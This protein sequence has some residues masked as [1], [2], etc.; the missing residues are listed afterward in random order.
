M[1]R[2]NC[3]LN[4]TEYIYYLKRNKKFEKDRKFCKHNLK[5]F[6]DVAR[7][8]QLINIEES[9]GFNKEIIYTTAILHDIGKSLQYETGTPHEIASWEISKE[10]LHNYR[11]NEEEI[12][13]IRQGILGHRDKK[14]E[15]FAQLMYRAD[16]LSRLCISCKSIDE[17]NWGDE[18]KNFKIYY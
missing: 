11:Y 7:I 16:K 4:D 2:F 12:E 14:S 9:L 1:D 13:I 3:I 10:I 6:L 15:N 18:K 5:H 17:C 8:A